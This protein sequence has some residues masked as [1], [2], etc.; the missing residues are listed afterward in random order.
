MKTVR[1]K[2]YTIRQDAVNAFFIVGAT[3]LQ[4]FNLAAAK[5]YVIKH[6]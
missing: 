2:G 1:Y 3:R 6:L 5:R 4:F